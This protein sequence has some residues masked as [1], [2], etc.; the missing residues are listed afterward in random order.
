MKWS[1]F[2]SI[3][4]MSLYQKTQA[5]KS[6]SLQCHHFLFL[7]VSDTPFLWMLNSAYCASFHIYSLFSLIISCHCFPPDTEFGC[8]DRPSSSAVGFEVRFCT[9]H[10]EVF[11]QLRGTLP[12][13]DRFGSL[14]N[15]IDYRY[16]CVH[17]LE[18][19]IRCPQ[20]CCCLQSMTLHKAHVNVMIYR[21]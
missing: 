11:L 7:W 2:C 5:I 18:M 6:F 8:G 10:S 14:S 13:W 17:R 21:C 1:F 19:V 16:T 3:V 4:V 20:T 15:A 9:G 12:C